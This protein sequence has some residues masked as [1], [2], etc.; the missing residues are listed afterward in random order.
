[1][2]YL[3]FAIVFL[4]TGCSAIIDL[5]YYR[6]YTG[7]F[8]P[9]NA[10]AFVTH[11]KPYSQVLNI[12]EIDGKNVYWTTGVL[13]LLP[14]THTI[15]CSFADSSGNKIIYSKKP[16]TFSFDVNAGRAY[17]LIPTLNMIKD[18]EGTWTLTVQ[19][20]TTYRSSHSYKNAFEV[21]DHYW[22]KAN[23]GQA[24]EAVR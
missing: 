14:G 23:S 2:K 5:P 18:T 3:L 15:I 21:I 13:E 6:G 10:V 1:M 7:H 11:P 20:I 19:D 8:K 16:E 12:H 9:R 24:V 22:Q 17:V 4:F